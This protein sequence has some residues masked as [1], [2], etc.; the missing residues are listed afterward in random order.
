MGLCKRRPFNCGMPRMQQIDMKNKKLRKYQ[1]RIIIQKS[2]GLWQLS[3]LQCLF[4]VYKTYQYIPVVESEHFELIGVYSSYEDANYYRNSIARANCKYGTD[5]DADKYKE[6]V[7]L[8]EITPD[9]ILRS[10]KAYDLFKD[11]Y[12][13]CCTNPVDGDSKM[14][15]F[16]TE[17]LSPFHGALHPLVVIQQCKYR[18]V[19]LGVVQTDAKAQKLVIA[20]LKAEIKKYAGLSFELKDGTPAIDGTQINNASVIRKYRDNAEL[21]RFDTRTAICNVESI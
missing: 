12:K 20:H 3:N 1:T 4:V 9:H 15:N 7:S 14:I 8:V 21:V 18:T 13:M 5:D 16:Q 2:K 6:I 19:V 11:E 10:K 17:A